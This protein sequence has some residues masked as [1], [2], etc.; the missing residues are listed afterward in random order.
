MEERR[1]GRGQ[2]RMRKVEMGDK[3]EKRM[4]ERNKKIKNCV[5]RKR[6]MRGGG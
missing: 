2:E 3:R 1:R 5:N 4:K 6:Y